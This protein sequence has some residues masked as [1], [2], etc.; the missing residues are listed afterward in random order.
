VRVRRR[1][2]K[3]KGAP[4][5]VGDH[6]LVVAVARKL[7][8]PYCG[9]PVRLFRGTHRQERQFHRYG[10]SWSADR[11]VA[12]CFAE[13]IHGADGIVLE[14]LAP[15]QAIIHQMTYPRPI[16]DPE[17]AETLRQFPDVHF[18]E[19][20]DEREYLVD[21][22]FLNAVIVVH[23]GANTAAGASVTDSAM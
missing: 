18:D 1:N 8:T 21:R 5:A 15:P 19:Y 7:L 13:P 3:A 17:R 14:T 6:R 22:K 9:P 4:L 2:R 11:V 10:L 20:H 12:E 23:A 16:T